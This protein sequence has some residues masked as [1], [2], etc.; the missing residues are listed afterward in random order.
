MILN[1]YSKGSEMIEKT[2]YTSDQ[3]TI[4]SLYAL[5]A[6]GATLCMIPVSLLPFAGMACL[7]VGHIAAYIYKWRYSENDFMVENLRYIIRTLWWSFVILMVGIFMFGCLIFLNGDLSALNNLRIQT[8]KGII[9]SQQ[10]IQMMQGQFVQDNRGLILMSAFFCL[11][12][13]PLY[14]AGRI[15]QK[16]K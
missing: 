16:V 15:L 13:Y 9:P 2:K 3:K 7:L 14:I 6:A 12:P 4:L 8:D 10:D 5:I 11:M 1:A